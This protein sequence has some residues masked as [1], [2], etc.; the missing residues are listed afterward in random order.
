MIVKLFIPPIEPESGWVTN[1]GPSHIPGNTI[2]YLVT[3]LVTIYSLLV[4]I[5]VQKCLVGRGESC[6][7]W[8]K[9]NKQ[10][11]KWPQEPSKNK[12]CQ[13]TK[14]VTW[15]RKATWPRKSAQWSSCSSISNWFWNCT[16]IWLSH[17]IGDLVTSL[18]TS[19]A[20]SLKTTWSHTWS[21]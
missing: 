1:Q 13:V 15:S 2:N 21:L 12:T 10:E 9:K 8:N 18:V 14:M 4:P 17:K 16:W 7:K 20:R 3:N 19:V 11:E 6:I 5:D